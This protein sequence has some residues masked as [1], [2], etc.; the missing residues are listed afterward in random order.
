[1]RPGLYDL[2][3]IKHENNV[4]VLDRAE[5]MSN[6]NGGSALCRRVQRR[7]HDLFGL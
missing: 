7:L 3:S 2:A 5:T 1:M 4:S 6:G